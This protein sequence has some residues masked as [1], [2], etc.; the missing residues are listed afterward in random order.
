MGIAERSE[1][2]TLASYLSASLRLG[3]KVSQSLCQSTGI[4]LEGRLRTA[5]KARAVQ[6]KRPI[7]GSA[8][9]THFSEKIKDAGHPSIDSR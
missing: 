3:W 7:P 4:R 1:R 5:R 6:G 2:P 9:G 8:M